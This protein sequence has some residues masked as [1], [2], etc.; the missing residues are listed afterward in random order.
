MTYVLI[1]NFS[2]TLTDVVIKCLCSIR[3]IF[4]QKYVSEASSSISTCTEKTSFP[5]LKS[6][7][8][9]VMLIF[10]SLFVI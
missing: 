8:L 5:R 9:C 7:F 6:C 3:R 2:N 10:N 1:S 4:K